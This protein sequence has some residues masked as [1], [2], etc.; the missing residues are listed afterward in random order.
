MEQPRAPR[1]RED[2]PPQA[3]GCLSPQ[4]MGYQIIS[5]VGAEGCDA[6]GTDWGRQST[7]AARWVRMR[8]VSLRPPAGG[9]GAI[10][11]RLAEFRAESLNSAQHELPRECPEG[12]LDWLGG[13]MHG[14]ASSGRVLMC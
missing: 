2:L 11:R 4:A 13:A 9:G 1:T 14:L 5:K 12:S 10:S 8:V 7:G 3:M 6:F